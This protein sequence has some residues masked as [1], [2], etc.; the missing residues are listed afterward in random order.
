MRRRP[1]NNPRRTQR[2]RKVFPVMPVSALSDII[3]S[4]R[5]EYFQVLLIESA[6]LFWI[7]A[8]ICILFGVRAGRRYIECGDFDTLHL[9]KTLPWALAFFVLSTG[10]LGRHF[11][12]VPFYRQVGQ[13]AISGGDSALREALLAHVSAQRTHYTVWASFVTTWVVLEA[14]IVYNGWRGYCSLRAV[15]AGPQKPIRPASVCVLAFVGAAIIGSLVPSGLAFATEPAV[16]GIQRMIHEA[17]ASN[18][19]YR[20]AL[21][22]YLRLAGVAWILVEWFAAVVLWRS[23]RLMRSVL[24]EGRPRA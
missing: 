18:A 7:F 10:L 4:A 16:E 2:G 22:L 1:V 19:L 5:L 12:G 21:Y 20:N 24:R 13:L 23:F 14:C 15:F 8:E 9:R 3:Q 6:G 11:L 17:Q